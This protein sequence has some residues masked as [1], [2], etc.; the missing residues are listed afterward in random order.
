V[1]RPER[2]LD[3]AAG[4]VE[5]LAAD[6]RRLRHHAG[7]PGYRELAKR[8]GY[9]AAAL[10]NA[11]AG[12]Q[13]PTLAVTLAFVRACDGEPAEWERRWR[14]VSAEFRATQS[15]RSN[16]GVK[17]SGDDA[18]YRGLAIFD[19]DDADY[20]FGR[21]RIV[22]QLVRTLDR[23]PFLAVLGVSGSGKSSLLRAGLVPAFSK[24]ALE[25]GARDRCGPSI[26][27]TPGSEPVVALRKALEPVLPDRDVLLVV[28]QFEEVFTHCADSPQRTRFVDD[29]AA[30]LDQPDA[31]T[32]VVIGVRADF[33][34]QCVELPKLA[35]L[36]ARTSVPVGTLN[37]DELREVITKPARRAGLS[38]ERALVTKIVA[39]AAGQPGS[40]PLVSHALLETW[41][42]RRSTVLT[43]AGYEATGGVAGAIAQTAEA[44]YRGF[45]AE[46]RETVREVLT[47][48][49][50]LGEKGIQDTRR[51]ADRT[52]LD[53]PGV[54]HVL[55]ELAR[56][57]LI[58]LGQDTVEIAHEAVIDAWPRLHDWLHQD[59][60]TLRLH[61]QLA[62]DSKIWCAHDRDPGALYRGSRLAAWEGRPLQR[63]NQ[64]EH[65]FLTTS[66]EREARDVRTRRRRIR[67]ALSSLAVGVVVTSL[68]AGLALSQA[69]R[70]KDERD[71]ALSHQLVAN[72]RGQL[73][74][75]QELAVLLA[76]EAFDTKPIDEA[77]AVLRQAVVDSRIRNVLPSGQQ[78]VFGV[79]YAPDGRHVA[80]SGADGMVRVWTFDGPDKVASQ[81]RVLHG[82]IGY[83]WS[84]VFSRD[85]R[86]LA[87]CG[88]DGTVTVWDLTMGGPP[89]TLRGHGGVVSNV[90]FSPDAERVAGAGD[91]GAIRVWDRAGSRDPVLL[92]LSGGPAQAVA[93]SPD[94]ERLAAAGAGPIMIWDS[95]GQ[96]QPTALSGH[97]D[98][99]ENIAFSPD[100]QLLAS[101]S[102]DQTARIWPISRTGDPVVLRAND[103]TVETVAFSPDGQRLATG[104]SGS[105]TI[106]VWNAGKGDGE[107]P[108]VLRGHDGP[109]WSVAFSP[110]G[111]R[112][113]SGSGD[114]TLRFWDPSYPGNPK[115]L[116]GH[117]G[118]AWSV[119]ASHDGNRIA[120]AGEDR[121][122][123]VWQGP[124]WQNPLVLNGH[125]GEVI[126]VA[127]SPDG[128][129]VASGSRDR[130]VR[131]WDATTGTVLSVL[132][133]HTKSVWS[134][135]FSPDGQ[136]LVSGS[137]DGTLR[138]SNVN[139]DG[140]PIVLRGHESAVSSVAYS[141][142]G[143]RIASTS[144]DS[145]VRIWNA[146]GEGT[147]V[148][149]R[150]HP[151]LV[152][153]VAF[154]PD[155]HTLATG[156][157]DGNIRIWNSD[158]QG[159]P[160]VLSGHHGPVWSVAFSPDGQRIASSGHDG[161]QRVWQLTDRKELVVFRGHGAFVEQVIF[162]PNGSGLI[163]AHG[164]GT[165]RLYQCEVC[166]PISHVRALADSRATR[167]MTPDERGTYLH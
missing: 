37:E 95:S 13:L 16:G 57:R 32:R 121:I 5:S 106:R 140:P 43:V 85:G 114:G 50:A 40:L 24:R 153:R 31:T 21:T 35:S 89:V 119:A 86:W 138:I 11:A 56:V 115:V 125:D 109:V 149:L 65:E 157:D 126:T 96:G 100:G 90:S 52:E 123:R 46:H 68:L 122:V 91:D 151:G 128:Q 20:F 139:G 45:D 154:A 135:A 78:Q 72:A 158:G 127:L 23:Q 79:A 160:L 51:R 44:V 84:P 155:G 54:D 163:A 166:G 131:I 30:L 4:P 22:D 159:Q 60:E 55:G 73:G 167:P 116:R 77:A 129:R 49:V 61:R 76:K 25:A 66:R 97:E 102:S 74:V 42:Q 112:L 150:G 17:P 130:T 69:S 117:V 80:S 26:V 28:D 41:R 47:R 145:T 27:I 120:S 156:G 18:P 2:S 98:A 101:A 144:Q 136:Q 53:F 62:E 82:H 141:P 71:R 36:L 105:D 108:L 164:D 104:H 165:I 38:V 67:L 110:D 48:L 162:A 107:D 146:R 111:N 134:V 118:A 9:S 29:I 59:R 137:V 147:P 152:W 1:P 63:L 70:A 88:V 81:P 93:F 75:D 99:V 124:Q 14:Q 19:V 142:D 87:A 148:V 15:N 132:H 64:R 143:R 133:G 3:P 161:S 8:S 39:D 113:V 103:G 34:A 58:V 12:R 33:Y 7:S 92:A 94:G 6:L 83:V 10:A